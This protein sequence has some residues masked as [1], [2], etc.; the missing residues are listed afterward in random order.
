MTGLPSGNAARSWLAILCV[1]YA[2]F[3]GI[4][5]VVVGIEQFV[6]LSIMLLPARWSE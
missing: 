2:L 6:S 3:D 1:S 4:T 5:L